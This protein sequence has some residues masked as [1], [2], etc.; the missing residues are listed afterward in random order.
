M[1]RTVHA[2]LAALYWL[3]KILLRMLSIAQATAAPSI[4]PPRGHE[5]EGDQLCA[6]T[7]SQQAVAAPLPGAS[8]GARLLLPA[9][10]GPEPVG[11]AKGIWKGCARTLA[12][13]K[14]RLR[15]N[16][17]VRT[18]SPVLPAGSPRGPP[19]SPAQPARTQAGT[20]GVPGPIGQPG[21]CG[22]EDQMGHTEP[23]PPAH[24][25]FQGLIWLSIKHPH[26][27]GFLV[28]PGG[29]FTAESTYLAAYKFS[30][31]LDLHFPIQK[32][33]PFN[34]SVNHPSPSSVFT[35]F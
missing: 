26:Q 7:H 33:I 15:G 31:I 12:R 30:F 4:H 23:I 6:V 21:G 22:W 20:T 16:C 13:E 24:P 29:C 35:H 11:G 2:Q 28:F 9:S 17:S 8:R 32:F 34:H 19:Q 5:R 18:R 1:K 27:R 10:P 25:V 14:R 3:T